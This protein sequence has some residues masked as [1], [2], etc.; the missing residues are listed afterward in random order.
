M[1]TNTHTNNSGITHYLVPLIIIVTV[2]IGGAFMLVRSYAGT[3]TSSSCSSKKVFSASREKCVKANTYQALSASTERKFNKIASKYWGG[4]CGKNGRD[5]KIDHYTGEIAEAGITKQVY[6]DHGMKV[7]YGID[8][9]AFAHVVDRELRASDGRA[10]YTP[11]SSPEYCKVHVNDA[12]VRNFMNKKQAYTTKRLMCFIILHQVGHLAGRAD[13]P[14]GS[15]VSAQSKDNALSSG[16][17]QGALYAVPR[18]G[19]T[20]CHRIK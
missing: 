11:Q 5:I 8:A 12:A 3:S 2:A 20:E 7:L 9:D 16:Y 19:D 18:S 13:V 15:E 4:I 1:Y 17:L 6:Y 10:D 14:L